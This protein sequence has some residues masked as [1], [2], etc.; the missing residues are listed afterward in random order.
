MGT[1]R[2]STAR[3]LGTAL[4][5]LRLR[6]LSLHHEP[7]PVRRFGELW[8][9]D[10]SVLGE[11]GNKVRKLEWLL[12]ALLRRDTRTV[13][14]A[15]GLG[16]NWGL[17]LARHA[18][19]Q[20]I[21]TELLLVEQPRTPE[22][23]RRLAQLR[24]V[25]TVHLTR[26]PAHTA[27]ALPGVLARAALRDRAA[28]VWLPP[29]GSAPLGTLGYVDAALELA[30]QVEA[31]ELPEPARV[32]TAVGSGGTAAGLALG[33][34]LAGLRT[35]VLGVV[36]AD[37]LRLD[38]RALSRRARAAARLLRRH[39]AYHPIP[40]VDPRGLDVSFAQLGPGYGHPT[41]AS[42]RALRDA[43]VA[44]DP[45]YSAKAFAALADLRQDGR[46]LFLRT[47]GSG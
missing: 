28:P 41:A 33:L 38:T 30:A 26:D 44:L 21:A 45:V 42:Q 43:P 20:G 15:G 11:G 22:V 34:R 2:P 9:K 24:A 6:R 25:A 4:P 16:T 14:S 35:R 17:A 19:E 5:E 27:V 23:E 37:Q 13:V 46:V 1:G 8:V 40:D 7:T 3:S 10:E 18:A 39:G 32:V 31:G 12:P 29:G 47:N 36:V